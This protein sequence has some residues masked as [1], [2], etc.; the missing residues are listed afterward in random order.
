[1]IPNMKE[2]TSPTAKQLIDSAE[3]CVDNQDELVGALKQC[4]RTM[5]F[6]NIVWKAR[7]CALVDVMT[8]GQR[9]AIS[10]DNWLNRVDEIIKGV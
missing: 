6:E 9:G 4:L 1:M 3:L 7:F 2:V 5:E 10:F 8:I